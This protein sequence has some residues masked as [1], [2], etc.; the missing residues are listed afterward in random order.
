MNEFLYKELITILE[1]MMNDKVQLIHGGQIIQWDETK[2][3]EILQQI[4][5][6]LEVP[7]KTIVQNGSTR[8][9]K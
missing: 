1:Q 3:P 8:N 4:K 6:K 2:I 7:N 9:H 5:E